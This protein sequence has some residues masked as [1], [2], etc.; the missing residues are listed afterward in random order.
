MLNHTEQAQEVALEGRFTDL[1]SGSGILEGTVTVA[2]RD[3]LVLLE[4][5]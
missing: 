5:V 2:P 3:V 1:L 4:R